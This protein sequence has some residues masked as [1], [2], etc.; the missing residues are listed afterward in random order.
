MVGKPATTPRRRKL[1]RSAKSRRKLA[2]SVRTGPKTAGQLDTWS[3]AA[4]EAALR[5][6]AAP[7]QRDIPELIAGAQK[8]I[9]R[10]ISRMMK[11]ESDAKDTR[12][13]SERMR[14]YDTAEAR[15]CPRRLSQSICAMSLQFARRQGFIEEL[16]FRRCSCKSSIAA[17]ILIIQGALSTGCTMWTEDPESRREFAAH[18]R[19]GP[20]QL[21]AYEC[22]IINAAYSR[23]PCV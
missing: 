10:L 19:I 9:Q 21:H 16:Q 13:L 18:F 20:H 15:L 17:A 1:A 12:R 23:R 3:D 4:A 2:L 5:L 6:C 7:L 22:R 14:G 11:T 8:L